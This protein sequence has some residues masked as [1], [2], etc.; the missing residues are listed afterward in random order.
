MWVKEQ[1]MLKPLSKL[2]FI[3]FWTYAHKVRVIHSWRVEYWFRLVPI[4]KCQGKDKGTA[5]RSL[6]AEASLIV[7]DKPTALNMESV[8]DLQYIQ[9]K[10]LHRN[11]SEGILFGLTNL[12]LSG[13]PIATSGRTKPE[14]RK[15]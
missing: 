10:T 2:E 1:A 3:D 6:E 8:L 9:I 4:S 13:P 7:W 12:S 11:L 5:D 14:N 15:V